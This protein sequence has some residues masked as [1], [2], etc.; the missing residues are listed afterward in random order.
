MPT[1]NE[2][3]RRFRGMFWGLVVGDCLGSPI[4]FTGKDSHVHVTDIL[5][6]QEKKTIEALPEYSCGEEFRSSYNNP[7]PYYPIIIR[8]GSNKGN[9]DI[10]PAPTG[11]DKPTEAPDGNGGS[12]SPENGQSAA[13]ERKEG[14]LNP[15][16]IILPAAAVLLAA[17]GAFLF[18]RRRKSPEDSVKDGEEQETQAER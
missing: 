3:L 8:Y 7:G 18:L 9:S 13:D 15:L 1:K 5:I 2:L 17:A 4:Q 12:D 11:D 10:T 14:K 16:W 6:N